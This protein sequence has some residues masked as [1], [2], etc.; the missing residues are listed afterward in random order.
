MLIGKAVGAT[1]AAYFAARMQGE[2]LSAEDADDLC[3]AEF[4]ERVGQAGTQLGDDEPKALRE[5]SR[6]ALRAY[7]T[8]LAPSAS[9]GGGGRSGP[10]LAPAAA[11]VPPRAMKG[12]SIATTLA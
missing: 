5:Q 3:G 4:D 9:D 12:A 8:E 1:I 10:A 2:A 7:L 11:L 6:E